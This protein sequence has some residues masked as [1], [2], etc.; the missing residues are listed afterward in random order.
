M[1]AARP[2]TDDDRAQVRALH[3]AGKNR[4][5]IAQEIGRSGATVTKLARELGITFDRSK[6]ATATHARQVDNRARRA[7]LVARLYGRAEQILDRL[8]AERYT[9]TATTI[10]GIEST[11][12]DHVPAPDEKALASALSTHLTAAAKLEQVDAGKGSDSVRS[13]LG[14]LAVALGVRT[15]VDD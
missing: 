5:Q 7:D 10:N 6:T 9:F 14:G 12:L 8:D 2:L 13:M 3:K 4:N 15:A 11:G 1:P